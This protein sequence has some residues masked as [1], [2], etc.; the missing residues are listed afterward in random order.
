VKRTNSKNVSQLSAELSSIDVQAML[1]SRAKDAVLNAA[2][3]LLELDMELL[4][5]RPFE[6]KTAQELCHRGG[7]EKTSIMLDGS[8]QSL[9][10]PRARNANGEV[11]L[12]SLAKLRD[13]ELL[14]QQMQ[15][16]LVRGVSTRNY[17]AV[18]ADF[19]GKTGISKSSVSRAFKRASQKDLDQINSCDLSPYKFV[20]ILIDGTNIG[21]RMVVVAV[22]ITSESQKIPLGLKEG[23]TENAEVVKDL[24]TSLT[25][26]GFAL[27]TSRL[28]AMLDGGKA[29]RAAVKS[30]WGDAV[31]IQRCWLHKARNIEGYLPKENHSQ[32]WRR[33]KKMMGLISKMEAEKEFK[34]LAKWLSEISHDAEKSLLEAGDEL[35]TVHSLGVTGEF[36]NALSTTNSIESLIGVSKTKLRNV[37]NWGYHPKTGVKVPRD[38]ALRWIA[39]AIQTHRPKMRALRGGKEQM[40]ILINSLSL[41]DS[42]QKAA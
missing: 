21:G 4:C 15:A 3:E 23:E 13:R 38:K 26:R 19:A 32:L 29:L 12:R 25:A 17:E 37:K 42:D 2:I 14:D 24:L 34:S 18:V 5:G 35:L 9:M 39:T 10:R 11:T 31:I 20:A 8:M 40:Q 28:L 41:L 7:S 33:M 16:K 30:L 1:M 6:R 22:G 27:K 36:R